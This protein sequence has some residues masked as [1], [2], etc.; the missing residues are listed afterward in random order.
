MARLERSDYDA[1][2]LTTENERQSIRQD[3]FECSVPD[4]GIQRVRISSV[5]LDQD[6]ALPHF[7]VVNFAGLHAICAAIA[8]D[9]ECFHVAFL[10]I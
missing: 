5:D 7:R 6:V 9:D 3:Q 2:Q 4:L 10:V 1:C 8:I